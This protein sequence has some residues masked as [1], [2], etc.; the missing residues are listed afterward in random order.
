MLLVLKFTTKLWV[1]MKCSHTGHSWPHRLTEWMGCH[2]NHESKLPKDLSQGIVTPG[3]EWGISTPWLRTSFRVLWPTALKRSKD[4]SQGCTCTPGEERGCDP[5]ERT[6][7]SHYLARLAIRL[8]TLACCWSTSFPTHYPTYHWCVVVSHGLGA[9]R[10]ERVL[11]DIMWI[12]LLLTLRHRT[13]KIL[14]CFYGYLN[15]TG[16][17][18]LEPRPFEYPSAQNEHSRRASTSFSYGVPLGVYCQVANFAVN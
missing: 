4:L 17:N 11:H 8:V 16:K 15:F 14:V 3:E 5:L 1:W 18:K 2:G 6:L 10:R 7:I 12:A 9:L 13:S